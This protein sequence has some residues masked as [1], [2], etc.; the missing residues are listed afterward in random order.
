MD[1]QF[2]IPENWTAPRELTRALPRETRLT[3]RGRFMLVMGWLFLIAAI[4]L[5]VWM[6]NDVVQKTE[7][8]QLLR[9]Q[10]QE[11]NG[12]IARLW[13]A[14]RGRQHMVGYA[15]T[16]NGVRIKGEAA[17]PADQWAEIQKAGFLPVRYLPSDPAINHPAAWEASPNLWMPILAPAILA[18]GGVFLLWT[19]GR[20][21]QLAAEGVPAPGVITRCFRVKNGWR[22]RYQFRLKDGTIGKGRDQA[23]RKLDA[24]TSVCVLYRAESPGRNQL[25]PGCSY[26]VVTQ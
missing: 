21:K 8:S 16:A 5:Y 2:A 15:F 18:A 23:S 9:A 26:R 1:P 19:L 24:G 20:Q 22:V 14:D 7:R 3:A 13:S 10:G 25:Y 11:A 17:V 4:P 12:E 6:H